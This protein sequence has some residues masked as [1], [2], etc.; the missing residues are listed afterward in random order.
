MNTCHRG[1]SNDRGALGQFEKEA[2]LKAAIHAGTPSIVHF[3]SLGRSFLAVAHNKFKRS[4]AAPADPPTEEFHIT[5]MLYDIEGNLREVID[6]RDH[7]VMRYAYDIL[8]NRIHQT[9]KDAGE[10][11]TLNDVGGQAPLFMGQSRSQV[12]NRL[13]SIT[14]TRGVL[15]KRWSGA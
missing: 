15:H 2:A 11:W 9:G 14:K 13:R 3:D 10:R 1:T 5:R 8:G 6:A 12:S 4:D 7:S